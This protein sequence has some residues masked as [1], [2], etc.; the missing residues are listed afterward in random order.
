MHKVLGT[1]NNFFFFNMEDALVY[2][3]NEEDHIEH[4]KMIFTKKQETGLT[5]K[6]LKCA[7]FK[8]H[9]QYLRHLIYSEGI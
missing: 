2:V 8:R 3:S 7:F 1:L 9:L 5:L 6:L 4:L